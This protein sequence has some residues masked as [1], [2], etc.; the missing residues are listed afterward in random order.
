MDLP[1]LKKEFEQAYASGL[2]EKKFS[3]QRNVS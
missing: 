2:I 3:V 1:V